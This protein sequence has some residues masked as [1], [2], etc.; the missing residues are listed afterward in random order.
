LSWYHAGR[1]SKREARRNG[2]TLALLAVNFLAF[3][4]LGLPDGLLGVAWPSLRA[5]FALPLDALAPLLACFTAGYVASSF[6]AGPLLGY[7]NVGGLLAASCVLTGLSLSGY[8]AATLWVVV[9]AAAGLGGIGAGAVDVGVNAYVTTHHGPRMLNWMHAAYGIGAASGPMVMT[10]VLMAGRPW[11]CG[12]ALVAAGQLVL[13]AAFAASRSLWPP[14]ERSEA[15]LARGCPPIA[16]TLGSMTTWLGVA[17]FF[18]YTGLEAIAGVWAYSVLTSVRGLSMAHAGL[19]VSLYWTGLT[20]G[21]ILFGFVVDRTSLAPL[22]RGALLLVVVGA[23]LVC[24]SVS[25]YSAVLGFAL[26]GLGAGPIFPSFMADTPRRVGESH[27]T[28]AIGF[29]V[30]AA[31]LGQASL[32]ALV[33]YLARAHGLAVVAPSMLTAAL[34]VLVLHEAMTAA[35]RIGRTVTSR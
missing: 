26:L 3:V 15:K 11:Q 17:A 14:M 35:S 2:R 9:I 21:R 5:T 30:A 34:V 13:A 6:A 7:W 23:G 18:S 12:Y 29:Q 8:A 19:G 1:S 27:T 24:S 10:S 22:L 33:G 16:D 20:V 28:N 4:S 25:P 31:A 32:P